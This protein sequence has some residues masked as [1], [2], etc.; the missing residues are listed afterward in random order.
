MRF[1]LKSLLVVIFFWTLSFVVVDNHQAKEHGSYS[2]DY[3]NAELFQ[4][5]LWAEE[6]MMDEPT[7]EYQDFDVKQLWSNCSPID[8]WGNPYRLVELNR[9]GLRSLKSFS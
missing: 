8:P 4:I 5:R 6:Q 7:I 1:H 9:P 3:A 2:F